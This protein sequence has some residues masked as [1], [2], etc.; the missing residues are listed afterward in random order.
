VQHHINNGTR[1]KPSPPIAP[2]DPRGHAQEGP[3]C[4]LKTPEPLSFRQR[5]E[6]DSIGTMGTGVERIE[7]KSILSQ[8]WR[9]HSVSI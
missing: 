3:R 9:I 7:N 5:E 6:N 1:F 8:A 4:G 2:L